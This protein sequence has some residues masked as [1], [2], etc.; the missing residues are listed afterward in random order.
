MGKS[1]ISVG[2]FFSI[3]LLGAETSVFERFVKLNFFH[4]EVH[5]FAFKATNFPTLTTQAPLTSHH[6]KKA[7]CQS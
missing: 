6:L 5:F 7:S 2:C 1:G 3:V 4:T